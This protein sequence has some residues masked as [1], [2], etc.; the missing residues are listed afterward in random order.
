MNTLEGILMLI[1]FFMVILGLP[2]MI[3][4]QEK[5][6]NSE[7]LI[8]NSTFDS[9]YKL[10]EYYR[11]HRP[12]PSKVV[13]TSTASYYDYKLN[14]IAWSK[15]HRTC[16]SRDLK[17]YTTHKVTNLDNGKSVECFVNDYGPETCKDRIEHGL[18]TKESCIERHI[19]LSSCAFFQIADIKLGLINVKI[20]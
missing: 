14:G 3:A 16:A 17:R 10:L 8:N 13:A 5:N 7:Y 2:F 4:V 11:S 19:D 18:D 6:D 9:Q 20:E 1:I 15:D 12:S